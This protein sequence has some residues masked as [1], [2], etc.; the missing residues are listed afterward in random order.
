M[1]DKKCFGKYLRMG[2][3]AFMFAVL[4]APFSSIA[5]D[6]AGDAAYE[7]AAGLFNLGLWKQ[8]SE[9]Y[10]EY[11]AKHPRHQLADHAHFGLGLCYFNLKD[12]A[13]AAVE[14][15]KASKGKGPDRTETN[16]YLGQA[17][18][19]KTPPSPKSAEDAFKSGLIALGFER[20]GILRRSWDQK[21][22][23]AW[24]E[25]N[26][27][28]KKRSLAADVFVGLVEASYMRNNWGSLVEKVNAFEKVFEGSNAEQRVRVLS[29]AAYAELENYAKA[30]EAYHAAS[31][32]KGPDTSEALFRLGLTRLN[33]LKTY[34]SAAE[35]FRDFSKKYNKDPKL[36]DANYN[37]ALC[38]Y[39]GYYTGKKDQLPKAIR[40]FET[41]Y[42][43]NKKHKLATVAQ[44]YVG[45]LHHLNKDWKAS[46]RTLEP[47]IGAEDTDF[48]QLVFLVGDSYHRMKNWEKSAKHYM[49]YA[50]GN[51]EAQN[52][53]VALH[54]AG[55]AYSNLNKPDLNRA[56]AAYEL[57]ESKCP[58]SPHLSSARLKLGIIHY[59]A[60]RFAAAERPLSKI[61]SNHDLKPDADYF[62]AW[63]SLDGGKPSEAAKRFKALHK[64]L[65]RNTPKHILVSNA[66]LYQ[67]V[68]EYDNRDYITSAQTLS[69]FLKRYESH[70]KVDEAA[71]NLGLAYKEL[72]QWEKSIDSFDKVPRKSVLHDRALY[73]SAWSMRSSGKVAQAIPYYSDLLDQH[74]ESK[75]AN[76]AALELAEVE[77]ET[78]GV[79]SGP[80][81]VTRLKKLISKKTDPKLRELALYRLGI[82][83]F[84]LKNYKGSAEAFEDLL[85]TKSND[86][87]ISSAWQAGEARRQ[88]AQMASDAIRDKEYKAALSNYKRAI[89]GVSVGGGNEKQLQQQALLRVGET[90]SMMEDWTASQKSY[91]RFIE[92]NPKH[93][94]IRTAY[95][96]LGWSKHNQES[97]N[98]AISFYTKTVKDGI[99]DDTGA[100]AQFLLGE[101]FLEQEQ[102][103]K[104]RTEFSKVDQLYAFPNWQSKALLEM[105]RSFALENQKSEA[106]TVFNKLIEKY[107]KTAAAS[108]AKDQLAL[109][110]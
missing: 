11:F 33:H 7:A 102:Y 62:M 29:G 72:K 56:I 40:T 107:P 104:A 94:L 79:K 89:N 39:H 88:L 45:Q 16:L 64:R 66:N 18:L 91:T 9:S 54:N 6:K 106:K 37:E 13:S 86:L 60:G 50:K 93:R 61:P 80:D 96:G 53:D 38:Y 65:E 28:S 10:K 31:G 99:R 19:L 63:A 20:A 27:A 52:A 87:A 76:T 48:K 30:A 78:G 49:Q 84:S 47:L 46:V 101:C 90:E 8:A 35:N 97:Y 95:L 81:S 12:Y 3:A 24:V 15:D 108:A 51:E 41:F 23:A 73:E 59:Q 74:P 21:S 82:V 14:L 44:F 55:V 43:S 5:E 68:A 77:F 58:A 110:D 22:I 36:A 75:F 100:R 17:L 92:E 103:V 34:E 69:G 1:E 42:K 85:K 25:K 57:L 98:E 2:I 71:F 105:G 70:E 26:K 109:L 67:G 4:L 32:L 83:E